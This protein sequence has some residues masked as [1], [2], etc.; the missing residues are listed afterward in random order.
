[1]QLEFF[2]WSFF[3]KI[4][5][6]SIKLTAGKNISGNF[7]EEELSLIISSCIST[8][9]T[10]FQKVHKINVMKLFRNNISSYQRVI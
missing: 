8:K 4:L 7:S 5:A 9:I 3:F 10:V 2:L 6:T 1:M